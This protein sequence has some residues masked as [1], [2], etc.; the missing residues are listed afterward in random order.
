[1]PPPKPPAST[2]VLA[3]PEKESVKR[4]FA[5]PTSVSMSQD[6]L[7]L[8]S[9]RGTP[10]SVRRQLRPPPKAQHSPRT[11]SRTKFRL[12][13]SRN[14]ELSSRDANAQKTGNLVPASHMSIQSTALQT[15]DGDGETRSSPS[16]MIPKSPKDIVD[17]TSDGGKDTLEAPKEEESKVQSPTQNLSVGLP[18]AWH[19]VHDE[20]SGK[21]FFFNSTTNETTWERPGTAV[22]RQPT[23][24]AAKHVPSVS[25]SLEETSKTMYETM[26]A[27][28]SIVSDEQMDMGAFDDGSLR[29]SVVVTGLKGGDHA[30]APQ[31]NKIIHQENKIDEF[32][33]QK[34]I[35]NRDFESDRN[36]ENMATVVTEN[37]DFGE[38]I[39]SLDPG[40]GRTYY[41]N[42]L[43]QETS[44]DPPPKK[45]PLVSIPNDADRLS[46][47]NGVNKTAKVNQ[48]ESEW[49]VVS[50]P[51]SGQIYYYNLTTKET[52][53]KRP[54]SIQNMN[55]REEEEEEEKSM[56]D[57]DA[58]KI[59]PSLH[60]LHQ[61]V[62]EGPIRVES[63]ETAIEESSI[64]KENNELNDSFSLNTDVVGTQENKSTAQSSFPGGNLSE[65][66]EATVVGATVDDRPEATGSE[67]DG[68]LTANWTE[69]L[70]PTSGSKYYFNTVT[71]ETTWDL[72]AEKVERFSCVDDQN[73]NH[74]GDGYDGEA[75][76]VYGDQNS[77]ADTS[78]GR[79]STEE[80]IGSSEQS[81]ESVIYASLPQ[82][83]LV[84]EA[85]SKSLKSVDFIK[86]ESISSSVLVEMFDPSSGKPYY[87]NSTTGE[88]TWHSPN[89]KKNGESLEDQLSSL[90]EESEAINQVKNILSEENNTVKEK[91]GE[92][93]KEND[94]LLYQPGDE[95]GCS[96]E[97]N[98]EDSSNEMTGMKNANGGILP[99][100]W[101][102]AID[103]DHGDKFYYNNVTGE[104]SWTKPVANILDDSFGDEISAP[105]LQVT[106][107]GDVAMGE[108]GVE[109][110]DMALT[111][112]KYEEN[113]LNGA[114]ESPSPL[115]E[116]WTEAC[117]PS[118]GEIYY[119]NTLTQVTSWT[120]PRRVEDD[121]D[122][123]PKVEP[124]PDFHY[125][126]KET[127][128]VPRADSDERLEKDSPEATD[129]QSL[130]GTTEQKAPQT[131]DWE[132]HVDPQ[133]GVSYFCNESTE[134][135]RRKKPV[136]QEQDADSSAP[137]DEVATN[138]FVASVYLA[139]KSPSDSI[140]PVYTNHGADNVD[141]IS[142]V[143]E[144]EEEDEWEECVDPQSGATYYFNESTG[145]TRWNKPT[146]KSD[147]SKKDGR[148]TLESESVVSKARIAHDSSGRSVPKS[149]AG[150]SKQAKA[151]IEA[152]DPAS[153][154][155]YFVNEETGETSWENPFLT[156]EEP[157]KIGAHSRDTPNDSSS[158]GFSR[159][160]ENQGPL[161]D[162]GT[163]TDLHK[164]ANMRVAE[165]IQKKESK[166]VEPEQVHNS[167]RPPQASLPLG[168]TAVIDS[169]SGETY[170]YNT[171]TEETSWE[172]PSERTEAEP[173]KQQVLKGLSS[174]AWV[175]QVDPSTGEKY[176]YNTKDGTTSWELRTKENQVYEYDSH[177]TTTES[178]SA[179]SK[180]DDINLVLQ[181]ERKVHGITGALMLA[182]E[183]DVVNYIDFKAKEEPG[184]LLWN[185]IQIGKKSKGRFRSD[186]GVGDESSPEFAIVELLLGSSQAAHMSKVARQSVRP[187]GAA[188]GMFTYILTRLST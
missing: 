140:S 85:H 4:L 115:P 53:W 81:P 15:E 132:E 184:D 106:K 108:N 47:N 55:F 73:S 52:T 177:M 139:D 142:T 30:S 162:K 34:M 96:N 58:A 153:G 11:A 126:V 122:H 110:S 14:M 137:E 150:D 38:W 104:T 158:T 138:T 171:E 130:K 44:W 186:E 77:E 25:S 151:W 180:T 33:D 40:S 41:F 8:S 9:V 168:W 16:F 1:M 148:G 68:A 98:P 51:S 32:R 118:S 28:S 72:P 37:N 36:P 107:D 59:T 2:R 23:E 45:E 116:Y 152:V 17:E 135:T 78:N 172:C 103:P 105:P 35:N 141:Q 3:T 117:D 48:N 13:P 49:S 10:G 56:S 69:A 66:S 70:D 102:I 114:L 176:F 175:Q 31:Q 80:E 29:H 123:S 75:E 155:K 111:L 143:A 39:P 76:A 121:G 42:P 83:D 84:T 90:N 92:N 62:E 97:G 144:T 156:K 63:G 18:K 93:Q 119:Y 22:L 163:Q 182:D 165:E 136:A 173:P 26:A 46:E 109:S 86:R 27:P 125:H 79:K 5:T 91:I 24:V 188:G 181:N 19:I 170:Y 67:V 74:V 88:T 183:F 71:M 145:E 133:N 89:D 54:S 149:P 166:E 167:A 147:T 157:F 94:S 169:T 20:S 124:E 127:S 154:D 12:P 21:S 50:D 61:K 64:S 99:P 113:S 87:Y 187:K 161:G 131:F 160:R 179:K 57:S 100:N 174:D 120:R 164:S 112:G 60:N 6:K 128:Q 65:N 129:R 43:T 159:N 7:E 101:E 146:T 178:S 134:E 95:G 82:T 185:L